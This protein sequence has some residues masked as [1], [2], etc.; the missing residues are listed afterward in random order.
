MTQVVELLPTLGDVLISNHNAKRG[1][2][3]GRKE[4]RHIVAIHC[5]GKAG[6][7]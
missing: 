4:G 6:E 1:R 2:K 3:G 5:F 7:L